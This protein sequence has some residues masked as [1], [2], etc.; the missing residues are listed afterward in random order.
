MSNPHL[1][2]RVFLGVHIGVYQPSEYV[3]LGI[4]VTQGLIE[5]QELPELSNQ[6]RNPNLLDRPQEKT[7]YVRLPRD[8]RVIFGEILLIMYKISIV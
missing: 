3:R 8:N 5:I 2:T 1:G 7:L 4:G 6:G